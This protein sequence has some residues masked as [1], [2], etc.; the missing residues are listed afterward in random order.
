MPNPA[1][2][3]HKTEIKLIVLIAYQFFIEGPNP[4]EHLAT[5]DPAEHCVGRPSV[6]CTAT[7]FRI[8]LRIVRSQ[9]VILLA[10][11]LGIWSRFFMRGP[12]S[13]CAKYIQTTAARKAYP[14]LVV[15]QSI[16]QKTGIVAQT[17]DALHLDEVER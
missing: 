8:R 15:R 6:G 14:S 10:S 3:L 5:V 12:N 4:F 2:M 13:S 7:S 9:L 17:I 16:S 11:G 1:A